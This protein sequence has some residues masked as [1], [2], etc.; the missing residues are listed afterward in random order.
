MKVSF[1][2][3]WKT[4]LLVV[5]ILWMASFWSLR[6][7]IFKDG[8]ITTSEIKIDPVKLEAH[9]RFLSELNP[10]RSY[11]NHESMSLAEMY[12]VEQLKDA[13][14]D[15]VELQDVPADGH[16]Y[17]N[18]IARYGDQIAGDVLVVGAHYDV[19]EEANPG[20]DDNA[21]GVAG[22]IEL[23]RV[24]NKERP[25]LKYPIEFVAYTL[26]EPPFFA[27][28]E[29]GSV[30]HADSLK[31]KG[32]NAVLML[33]LEMIGYFTDRWFSQV[34]L[35]PLLY[36]IYPA[37]GNFIGIVG[38]TVDRKLQRDFK[39]AF[40]AN[41]SVPT[42]SMS[43]PAFVPGID[44]SDHRSYWAHNWPALMITDTAFLRNFQYHEPGDTADRL[45]YIKMAEVI[46]GVYGGLL[47]I[48]R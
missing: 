21:S 6:N 10:N 46:R 27:E 15:K 26:E 11:K 7:P 30:R 12:I 2:R 9:V 22:L 32:K 41:T 42:Y 19:A 43:S 40:I 1:K 20:A 38:S 14:F 29:M 31:E 36:G 35:F 23:A 3:I 4:L 34:H 24:V 13:G 18:V 28:K 16:I 33:S 47:Y 5:A 48:G 44:Y 37:T 8:E 39:A 45:N 17:H 25:I